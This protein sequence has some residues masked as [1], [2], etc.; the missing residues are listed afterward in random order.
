MSLSPERLYR[1]RAE[2]LAAAIGRLKRRN[3][4]FVFAELATF[5]AAIVAVAAYTVYGGVWLMPAAA[6]L[7]AAYIAVRRLDVRNGE[8]TARLTAL[9]S[10]YLNELCYLSGDFSPFDDGRRYADPDHP[11]TFDMDVF[12]PQSLFHRINRTV[13]TG[14]SDRLARMLSALPGDGAAVTVCRENAGSDEMGEKAPADAKIADSIGRI[15]LQRSA[16]DRLATMEPLRAGFIACGHGHRIDTAA[17]M[18]ALAGVRLMRMPRWCGSAA[19]LVAAWVALGGFFVTVLLS[20][21]TPMTSGVPVL[22][23]TVQLFVVLMLTN[24]PLHAMAKSAGRLH[25]EVRAYAGLMD[26]IRGH[27]AG[28][29]SGSGS[30][31]DPL[32]SLF[33]HTSRV[34]GSL[35]AFDSILASLDRRGNVLGMVLFDVFLLSDF[36]LVRRFCRWRQS[37]AGD[38]GEWIERVSMADA[39]VSM[40]TFRYNEPQ[41][42]SAEIVG[43]ADVV[44]EA[45][46]LWHPFLGAKA[47]RNDFTVADSHYYIV[48]GANMAGKSTFL[49]SLGVNYIL[50]MNGMPVF[51]ESLRVSL[52]SLFSSMRTSDDLAHGISYFNAELLR[53]RMLIGHCRAHRRTLIILDEILKG[54]NSLDK[55]NGSRMF[56]DAISRLPVSGVI[57]THDLELSRMADGGT[58]RFHNWCFEISLSD[59]ITYTYRITP[60]VARN[61][62][63]TYLLRNIIAD[64]KA[65]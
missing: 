42:G 49:R 19:A 5:A 9:R 26:V 50:A 54:T 55:L 15:A 14:G 64:I 52:F 22:W 29:A 7:L 16:I 28:E 61:Q 63:A 30:G 10:V 6:V 21:F 47:V 24:G 35:A 17:V 11:F 3:R 8:R 51:A 46:G 37:C 65:E 2:S 4:V 48:T 44:Y 20:V 59:D 31:A 58:G 12:G 13:T 53:L 34:A 32:S 45:R 40:A 36:F 18:S 23:G 1:S 25:R 62:N 38:L 39:L 27:A 56:L 41:A 33:D 57:A 60:G 43:S